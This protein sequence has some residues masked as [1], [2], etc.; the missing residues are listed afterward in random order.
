MRGVGRE[1]G[2]GG[3]VACGHE[4]YVWRCWLCFC[5]C[6][7]SWGSFVFIPVYQAEVS[8]CLP[9]FNKRGIYLSRMVTVSV[10]FLFLFFWHRGSEI[11]HRCSRHEV[12][13]SFERR[14]M[15]FWRGDEG[16]AGG[17]WERD[18]EGGKCVLIFACRRR[19]HTDPSLAGVTC[20]MRRPFWS[21]FP[22]E[23]PVLLQWRAARHN[24]RGN[25]R[26]LD[27]ERRNEC[28]VFAFLF[29]LFRGGRQPRF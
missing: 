8:F 6:V 14:F 23:A 3:C 7:K 17:G 1:W 9:L 15:T 21:G 13:L 26:Y 18:G 27:P 19:G 25:S 2:E 24:E 4:R 12:F 11:F 22:V 20:W 16:R 10:D 29:A 5:P 28:F